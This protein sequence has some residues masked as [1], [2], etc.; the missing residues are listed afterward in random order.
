MD[1]LP[2][3]KQDNVAFNSSIMEIESIRRTRVRLNAD[4]PPW[5]WRSKDYYV[6]KLAGIKLDNRLHASL[7]VLQGASHQAIRI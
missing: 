3:L 6:R 4:G 2:G 1:A 5:W 7:L